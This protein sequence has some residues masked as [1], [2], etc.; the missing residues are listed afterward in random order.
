MRLPECQWV[1]YLGKTRANQL[2]EYTRCYNL[3][4]TWTTKISIRH[5]IHCMACKYPIVSFFSTT[6]A[7]SIR[8]SLVV[9]NRFT[10]FDLNFVNYVQYVYHHMKYT[11]N[12]L[13]QSRD[14]A[15]FS[16]SLISFVFTSISEQINPPGID[17]NRTKLNKGHMGIPWG[18]TLDD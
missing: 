4:K 6:T 11:P 9:A 17:I 15:M 18:Q 1:M 16:I 14:C 5:G 13:S 2:N 3:T 8:E 7:C 10:T 12:I